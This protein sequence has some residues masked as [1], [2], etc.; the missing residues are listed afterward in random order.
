MDL[1]GFLCTRRIQAI[2]SASMSAPVMCTSGL[3][4]SGVP[5]DSH[6]ECHSLWNVALIAPGV[7]RSCLFFQ[8]PCDVSS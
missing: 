3:F 2:Q 1:T 8:D 6:L 5:I 4:R 7:V